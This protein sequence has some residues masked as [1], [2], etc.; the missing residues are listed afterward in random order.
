MSFVAQALKHDLLNKIS[1]FSLLGDSNLKPVHILDNSKVV[2]LS[3]TLRPWMLITH[4]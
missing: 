1:E 3:S 4:R 2:F